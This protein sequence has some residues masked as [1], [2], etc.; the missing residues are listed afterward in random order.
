MIE[1][2]PEDRVGSKFDIFHV[3]ADSFEQFGLPRPEEGADLAFSFDET[4]AY[5]PSTCLSRTA[6]N[7]VVGMHMHPYVLRLN[8]WAQEA[9]VRLEY[10]A[11]FRR[12]RFDARGGV[13]GLV[14][15]K[16]GREIS[17]GANLVADCSGIPS[18]ARRC[19]PEGCPVENFEIAPESMYYVLLRYLV[20]RDPRED[21]VRSCNWRHYGVWEAPSGDPRGSILGA[22][23]KGSYQRT[24]EVFHRFDKSVPLPEY[25]VERLERGCT[26]YRRTPYSMVCGGFAALGDAA[27]VNRINA[28]GVTF[29]MVLS[30][31]AAEVAAPVLK[32]G[33][34]PTLEELWPVNKRY[35]TAQ[36][37]SFAAQKA[38]MMAKPAWT[39]E[40]DEY[41]YQTDLF[42]T[43]RQLA[44]FA[45]NCP[46]GLERGEM[47][48]LRER[49][50][51]SGVLTAAHTEQQLRC[52]ENADAILRHYLD[53]PESPEGFDAWCRQADRLWA[54]CPGAGAPRGR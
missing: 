24:E 20:Y 44:A 38:L 51:Q 39:P 21:R 16:D 4:T 37:A 3:P 11:C 12:L 10:G 50:A 46:L 9:G 27:C 23:A 35:N 49:S 22:G 25:T 42:C 33:A 15:E 43:G 5:S 47:D 1:R 18:A 26:P 40:E 45:Q 17:A 8:R 2:D 34:R 32:R 28:E 19:L 48:A 30:G 53:Y 14:Y 52:M 7:H 36:G 31:L 41:I 13:C 54:D 29:A 6:E